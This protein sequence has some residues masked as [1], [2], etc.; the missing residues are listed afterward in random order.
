M[1]MTDPISDLLTRVRNGV[2]TKKAH[3]DV[4]PATAFKEAVL[5][6]LKR[7]GYISDFKRIEPVAPQGKRRTRG[8]AAHP[9]IRVW[10]KYHEDHGSVIGTI[11]RIS[12]PGCRVFRG[13]QYLETKKILDGLGVTILSTPR[14][15]LS[16]R[17]AKKQNVGGEILCEVW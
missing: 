3:V 10:L 9:L 7:E 16:D 2:R 15:V 12:K 6:A 4:T 13:V 1:S 14:G 17:E 11:R 5:A 8:K